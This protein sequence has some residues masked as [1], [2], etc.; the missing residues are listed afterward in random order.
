MHHNQSRALCC[1]GL[2]LGS[3]QAPVSSGSRWA[4]LTRGTT[5]KR[6]TKNLPTPHSNQNA[7]NRAPEHGVPAKF[8]MCLM[9][10][11]PVKLALKH[12]AK[13]PK[14]TA[15]FAYNLHFIISPESESDDESS[16]MRSSESEAVLLS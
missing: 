3:R 10:S 9:S 12:M 11:L 6:Y 2:L 7:H 13:A 14:T 16:E 1:T 8:S 15:G 4:L 5:N